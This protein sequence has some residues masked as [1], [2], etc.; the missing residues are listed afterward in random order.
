MSELKHR[1][2]VLA[3][4]GLLVA[5]CS[6]GA[7]RQVTVDALEG[8]PVPPA[9]APATSPSTTGTTTTTRAPTTSTAPTTTSPTT[10]EPPPVE[11]T[12]MAGG[13]VLLDRIEPAGIDPFAGLEPALSEA[14]LA[15]VNVEMAIADRGTP[16]PK[17]YTFRAP[18]SAAE[19]IAAGGVDIGNLGNNH[20][21]DFGA[22]ALLQTADLL[23]AAGVS[24]VG[25][26]ADDDAAFT[27]AVFDVEGV[28]V[29]VIGASLIIPGGFAARPGYPGVANGKDSRRLLAAVG[30]AAED[31]DVVIVTLHWGIERDTCPQPA[32][33]TYARQILDAGASA[34][35]AGHPHVLQPIVFEDGK[36]IAYSLGNFI[37]HPRGG[38]T[39]ETGV[40]E[41]DFE[42]STIV[43]VQFHPHVLDGNGA[44]V[45]VSE[46]PKYERIMDI[47]GGNC[48]EHD[49]PPLPPTTEAPASTTTEAPSG[50]T[51]PESST[52]APPTTEAP[53]STTTEAPS[54]TTAPESSTSAPPTT[55]GT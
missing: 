22:E 27:P 17:T 28:S 6:G 19:T 15:L 43:G 2:A 5:A 14:D 25:A 10:T 47:V 26:G 30:A 49:P 33:Q 51:A 35:I 24:P 3:A 21:R 46:G 12:F 20:A 38:I 52:S 53:A 45:P 55:S 44:P 4:V 41:L 34:V 50:T 18:L 39:G 8:G 13:D 48:E 40:L 42:D 11:W 54:G 7:T 31:N 9:P 16:Y 37:W 1:I 32:Q 36:V 29:A 23:A